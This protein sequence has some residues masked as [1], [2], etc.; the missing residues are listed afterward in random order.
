MPTAFPVGHGPHTWP[1]DAENVAANALGD[2]LRQADII[3][4]D[5]RVRAMPG[6]VLV[7][8]PSRMAVVT[9]DV[10]VIRSRNSWKACDAHTT[11][12]HSKIDYRPFHPDT[13]E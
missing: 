5:R 7:C 8:L 11:P 12:M 13:V 4:F 6:V 2:E 1:F 3:E 9:T 10:F